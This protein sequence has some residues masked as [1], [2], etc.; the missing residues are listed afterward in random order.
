MVVASLVEGDGHSGVKLVYTS[1]RGHSAALPTLRWHKCGLNPF[2]RQGLPFPGTENQSRRAKVSGTPRALQSLRT[3][4][5][6]H[7]G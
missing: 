4:G 6:P 2:E 5:P 1:A 7:N 3:F